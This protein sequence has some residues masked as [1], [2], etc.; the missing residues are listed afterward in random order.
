[1]ASHFNY[2]NIISNKHRL[3]STALD[4]LGQLVNNYLAAHDDIVLVGCAS[5]EKIIEPDV[6]TYGEYR[7]VYIAY[8][9]VAGYQT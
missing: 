8:Q 2:E 5:V 4:D 9:T 6:L 1:M 3:L 7:T